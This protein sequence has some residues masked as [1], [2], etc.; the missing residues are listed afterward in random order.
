MQPGLEGV[1]LGLDFELSAVDCVAA[2]FFL[3][4][5][6]LVVFCDT[7]G[8]TEGAGLYLSTVGC[9]GNVCNGRVFSFPGTV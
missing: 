8:T 1:S 7:V 3:N 9:D 6:E 5:E 2:Q 4:A